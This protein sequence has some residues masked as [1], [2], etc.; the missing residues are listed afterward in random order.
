MYVADTSNACNPCLMLNV[1]KQLD[2][3]FYGLSH[4]KSPIYM[5]RLNTPNI[6]STDLVVFLLFPYLIRLTYDSHAAP[7][8]LFSFTSCR[9]HSSFLSSLCS[10]W[11]CLTSFLPFC[12]RHAVASCFTSFPF[13]GRAWCTLLPHATRVRKYSR[14]VIGRSDTNM[15]IQ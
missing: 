2:F 11:L 10:A 9:M 6:I 7:M 13:H 3:F 5:L 8:L 1:A 12:H 14:T 4:L 15:Y